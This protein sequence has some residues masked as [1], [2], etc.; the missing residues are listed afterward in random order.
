VWAW[1]LMK[2]NYSAI[3]MIKYWLDINKGATGLM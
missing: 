3:A 1:S 2:T